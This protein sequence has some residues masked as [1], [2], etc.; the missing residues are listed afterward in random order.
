MAF[1]ESEECGSGLRLA[2]QG[3]CQVGLHIDN[4]R[5]DRAKAEELPTPLCGRKSGRR[6]QGAIP[7]VAN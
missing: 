2:F 5:H 7:A 4:L 3:Q 1:E 6:R